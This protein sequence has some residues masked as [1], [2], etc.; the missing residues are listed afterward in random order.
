M[1]DWT[2]DTPGRADAGKRVTVQ[3]AD[4]ARVSGALVLFDYFFT[5]EDEI[6]LYNV[7]LD[8]G[9]EISIHAADKWMF[10]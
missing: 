10:E 1:S 5:G 7:R 8:D 6:P 3:F 9:R 2:D 4:G